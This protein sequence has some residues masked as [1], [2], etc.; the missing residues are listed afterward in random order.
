MTLRISLTLLILFASWPT[1]AEAYCRTHTCQSDASDINCELVE[2]CWVG[3]VPVRWRSG[4]VTFAVERGGS[5]LEGL[6]APDVLKVAK[7]AFAFWTDSECHRGG[8]PPLTFIE[9]GEVGCA[10]PEYNCDPKDW[11]TNVILFQDDGWFHDEAALAITAVTMNLDTGEILDADIEINTL[12]FDFVLPGESRGADLRTVLMHEAGH[13]LG[14]DHPDFHGTI[15]Y[16]LYD[17]TALYSSLGDDDIAGI[18]E[19]YGGRETDPK[20]PVPQL[21]DDTACVGKSPC[22][23]PEPSCSCRQ[24]AAPVSPA[25]AI[26]ALAIAGMACWRRR[27]A[28]ASRDGHTV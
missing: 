27:T 12:G 1:T 4:C 3:G 23:A 22:V 5:P 26:W 16:G 10:Q 9:L 19:I 8:S 14:L 28:V 15:M 21:P 25:A 11:N 17:Q 24:G 18:C 7:Q 20:C 6:A 2:G 13:V